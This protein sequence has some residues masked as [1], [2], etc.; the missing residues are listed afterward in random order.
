MA[1]IGDSLEDIYLDGKI[2][3]YIAKKIAQRHDHFGI[4]GT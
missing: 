3:G 4:L 1:E 2:M